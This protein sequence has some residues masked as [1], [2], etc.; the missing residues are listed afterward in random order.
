MSTID[1]D[2]L[3]DACASGGPSAL[4][5]ATDLRPAAG[6]QAGI[7]PAKYALRQNDLGTYVYE[8]RFVDGQP[9][10]VVIIDSPQSVRNRMESAIA[11]EIEGGNPVLGRIP[12]IR[13]T[14]DRDHRVETYTDLELP[15]R[16]FDAHVRA[17]TVNGEPTTKNSDYRAARDSTPANAWSIFD[18][19]P[20]SLVFGSWDASRKARQGRW[21]STVTGE[22]LGVLAD[23]DPQSPPPRKGGARVDPV[24]MSTQLDSATLIA[25]AEAQVDELSPK[26]FDKIVKEAKKLK[27]GALGSASALGLGGIPPTLSQ[28]G[29]V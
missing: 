10:R 18:L 5:S 29:S 17:G 23:Q 7:A 8:T 14:Y 1:L 9:A 12:R 22:I 25:L 20:T 11:Q 15:H 6:A 2:L 24:G 27:A 26:T 21:P 28:L 4:S 13:V 16:A 19:S 3:L